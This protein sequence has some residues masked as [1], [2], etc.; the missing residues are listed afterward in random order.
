MVT[1]DTNLV[2][3]LHLIYIIASVA[4]PSEFKHKIQNT[5]PAKCTQMPGVLFLLV[6]IMPRN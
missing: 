4:P 2:M 5:I 6:K 1:T 3:S